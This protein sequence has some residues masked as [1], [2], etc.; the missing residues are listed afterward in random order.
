[1][2][3]TT[4]STI[5]AGLLMLTLTGC[6]V[7]ER[8][9]RVVERDYYDDGRRVEVVEPAYHEEVWIGGWWGGHWEEREHERH[10]HWR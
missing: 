4:I 5:F 1:M 10:H 8:P 6:V 7:Y 2:N 3:R 9:A